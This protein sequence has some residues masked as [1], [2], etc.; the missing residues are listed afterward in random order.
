MRVGEGL[1]EGVKEQ[2]AAVAWPG[3]LQAEGQGQASQVA[4]VAA[5]VAAL[6]V[7]GG[8]GMA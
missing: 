7:P 2:L 5:P 6:K 8:Q 3:W 4:L 1:G